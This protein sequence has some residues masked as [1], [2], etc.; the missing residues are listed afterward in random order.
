MTNRVIK[1]QGP[2]L[3]FTKTKPGLCLVPNQEYLL[4]VRIKLDRADGT[5]DGE[6]TTCKTSGGDEGCPQFATKIKML[7]D[8]HLN[9]WKA[10]MNQYDVPNYGEWGDWHD[11]ITF[12]EDELNPTNPYSVLYI[13]RVDP[14]VDISID[15][16]RISN[17]TELAYPDPEDVCGELVING[18]AEVRKWI[19][20]HDVDINY[21]IIQAILSFLIHCSASH[22]TCHTCTLKQADDMNPFPMQST[23]GSTPIFVKTE[24]GNN[25]FHLPNRVDSGSSIDSHL[26]V[27][28]LEQGATY[29]ASVKVR[30]RSEF[31]Q[32]FYFYFRYLLPG[33]END[34]SSYRYLNCPPQKW[35][36]GWVTCSGNFIVNELLANSEKVRARMYFSGSRNIDVDV[37][38]DDFSIQYVKGRVDKLVVDAEDAQCWGE[39]AD[40]HIGTSVYYSYESDSRVPNGYNTVI[41]E[42][43]SSGNTLELTLAESPFIPIVTA[44]EDED[45]AAEVALLSRNVKIESDTDE[46]ENKGAYLQVLHTPDTAQLIK[47][48]EFENMGRGGELDRYPVHFLYSGSIQGTEISWSSIHGSNLRCIAI[49]GTGNVTVSL[50]VAYK[51]KGHCI[52][53]GY[54]SQDNT[55]ERNFV[56]DTNS[57]SSSDKVD[58][59]NVSS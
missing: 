12:T 54:E 41:S 32:Q 35:D 43:T 30:I 28:C 50:N 13:D 49:E 7:D 51:N 18:D 14:G 31:D 45:Y 26:N 27:E 46:L 33:T 48:V 19:R 58:K 5:L 56:S 20:T 42:I 36:D 38:Y 11:T 52:Y 57:V 21:L 39:G 3:D 8:R 2:Y 15:S 29:Q 40:I 24:N 47:G 22:H 6:P 10:R 55:I 23:S 37:D 9:S 17:P 34:W 59:E 53:L 44:T 4:S 25:Y 16:I 1:E